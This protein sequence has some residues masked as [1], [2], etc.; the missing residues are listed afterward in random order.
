MKIL[1]KCRVA[2][3]RER[4]SARL[5]HSSTSTEYTPGASATRDQR[6]ARS[7][8]GRYSTRSAKLVVSRAL[9]SVSSEDA[10]SAV[11]AGEVLVALALAV[12]LA[13]AVVDRR[14]GTCGL[15]GNSCT[16]YWLRP[17]N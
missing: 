13:V 6:V 4:S 12:V 3:R 8:V 10:L 5:A 16:R 14:G 9:V 15:K 7:P 17:A 11:R 1:I 2:C